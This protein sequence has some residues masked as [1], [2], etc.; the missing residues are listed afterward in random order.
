MTKDYE[1]LKN[2]LLDVCAHSSLD[3]G[4]IKFVLSDVT[5]IIDSNYNQ[6]LQEE[7]QSEREQQAKKMAAENAKNE[8]TDN[9]DTINTNTAEVKTDNIPMEEG[10]EIKT[11]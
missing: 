4:G 11:E 6:A 2:T 7:I 1:I 5:R 3:I 8:G 10:N 9:S